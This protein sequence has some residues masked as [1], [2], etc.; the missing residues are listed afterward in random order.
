MICFVGVAVLDRFFFAS[1]CMPSLLHFLHCLFCKSRR[2]GSV[3]L[4]VCLY[5][6][7]FSLFVGFVPTRPPTSHSQFGSRLI[8][9]VERVT[10]VEVSY[11]D[12]DEGFDVGEALFWRRHGGRHREV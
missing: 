4:S 10:G 2:I 5:A 3:F 1:V 12:V 9:G 6:I 8:T 7:A 11:W